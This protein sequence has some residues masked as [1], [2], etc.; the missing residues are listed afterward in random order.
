MALVGSSMQRRSMLAMTGTAL[1]ALVTGCSALG[2]EGGD[3]PTDGSTPTPTAT[4]T[5]D[6][7][8]TPTATPGGSTPT[9]TEPAD[10]TPTDTAT[11]TPTDTGP[12][13]PTSLVNGSF[14]EGWVGWSI[15]R[16]LPEDPNREGQQAVASRVGVTTEDAT[17]GQASCRMFIDGSQD[18][19]TVWVQQPV[20]LSAYDY[21][22][23]DYG[24]STSFNEIRKAA[25]YAGP[26]PSKP[27]T[28][29]DFDTSKSLEGHS[30]S[31]WKTLTYE[32]DHDGPGL[33]AVGWSIVWETGA[34]ALFPYAGNLVRALGL[35]AILFALARTGD[36]RICRA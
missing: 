35:A 1:T 3:T 28:E 19:G 10:P 16:D 14:E 6:P 31:G 25:V 12:D 7:T 18:D 36:P 11:P 9:G 21:L 29:T 2:S 27:L 20:D 23:V 5:S 34:Y 17:H 15:G 33:V 22:A 26:E 24:V 32:I 4:P 8:A 13:V 30:R